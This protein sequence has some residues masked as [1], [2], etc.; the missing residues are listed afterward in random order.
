M[1]RLAEVDDGKA[2]GRG[3]RCTSRQK[4]TV[5]KCAWH[6][7]RYEN[8]QSK[9]TPDVST[10][11]I[12]DDFIP[13][14]VSQSP[15]SPTSPSALDPSAFDH[16]IRAGLASFSTVLV[17]LSQHTG[18][19][20]SADALPTAAPASSDNP[21]ARDISPAIFDAAKLPLCTCTLAD[22]SPGITV[23]WFK[24]VLSSI[25]LPGM[26]CSGIFKDS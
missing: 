7:G 9:R 10:R 24:R 19:T 15:T 14:P 12:S 2:L 6:V 1:H 25:A 3:A 13:L 23:G 11:R 17:Q 5:G 20:V 22:W 8:K 16:G 4:Q 18:R 21:A 26:S